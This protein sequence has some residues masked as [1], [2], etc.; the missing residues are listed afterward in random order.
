[1]ARQALTDLTI[2]RLPHPTEGQT[3]IWDTG[4]AG[5]GI[6]LSQ[7]TKSFV[8]KHDGKLT[9]LGRY[10]EISLKDARKAAKGVQVGIT[11][12]LTTSTTF[13]EALTAFTE[14]KART[15]K[16][17]TLQRYKRYL[18]AFNFTKKVSELTRR[19]I[20]EALNVYQDKP[21]AQNYA[22]AVMRIFLNW[23]LSE[24]IVEKHPMIRVKI[25]NRLK[26]RERVLTDDE[27][28]AVW[29]AADTAPMGH[30]VRIL[31][32][33][34]ARREEVRTAVVGEDSMTFLDTKNHLDHTLPLTPLVR[35]HLAPFKSFS[36]AQGKI[37]LD[38]RSKVTE[39]RLHD[40]RRTFST[41]C[42]RLGVPQHVVEKILNHKS[43]SLSGVAAIYNR[44]NYQKE[45]HEALLTHEAFI[46][47]L[48]T[49]EAST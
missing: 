46:R 9:T 11:E 31:I 38:E 12:P 17:K 32:L 48:V 19:D 4:F 13:K 24:Q 21:P 23:C 36:W 26:S 10:P 1:M 43:G 41:N 27:L 40:L 22:F 7:K 15:T 28:R 6:R 44:W 3:T 2:Q 35:E 25:P 16:P 47:K 37:A 49:P 42:A 30:I 39:W 14:A 45:M 20:N 18:L 34:G 5:F 29:N 8:V 33:T